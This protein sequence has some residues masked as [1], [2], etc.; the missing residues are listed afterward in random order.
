MPLPVQLTS[1][2]RSKLERGEAVTYTERDG[3][4][5]FGVVIQ[6]IDAP[7]NVCFSKISDLKNYNKMVPHVKNVDVYEESKLTNG[8]T[9]TGAKFS[10]GVMGMNIEYYLNLRHEPKYNTLSWTLDFRHTSDLDDSVG[11][12]QV[13]PHPE[14]KDWT[15]ILYSTK[16]KLLPWIPEFAV[17]SFTTQALT[18][19]TGWVKKEAELEQKKRLSASSVTVPN[20]T[21]ASAASST[22]ACTSCTA[23][24]TSNATC[25]AG[26]KASDVEKENESSKKG[27]KLSSWFKNLKGG[28]RSEIEKS[29][30]RG[31]VQ[32]LQRTFRKST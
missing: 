25:T 10:V 6:D 20:P 18:E 23:R 3:K 14:R 8:S 13:M 29:A 5:G 17:R 7:E 16:I 21:V 12:W 1:D 11:L 22:S 26:T 19:A 2:Q 28:S 30:S 4:S 27:F 9:L 24:C 31:Y 15:R 32:R